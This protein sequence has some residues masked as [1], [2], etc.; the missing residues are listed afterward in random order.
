MEKEL[1]ECAD[2][3]LL[4]DP[5]DLADVFAREHDNQIILEKGKYLGEKTD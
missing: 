2:C 4:L 1:I 5:S 3:G